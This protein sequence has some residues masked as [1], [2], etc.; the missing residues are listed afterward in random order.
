MSGSARTVRSFC[1]ISSPSLYADLGGRESI[2]PISKLLQLHMSKPTRPK[3]ST[4]SNSIAEDLSSPNSRP[5]ESSSPRE[6][7]PVPSSLAL[8]C[9][10]VN[11][12]IT[13]RKP[14]K[15]S[16]FWVCSGRCDERRQKRNGVANRRLLHRDAHHPHFDR[17]ERRVVS[18][19]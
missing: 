15:K 13:T 12:M 17:V 2:P 19:V 8:T 14:A 18:R 16:V 7:I 1:P 3:Q 10:R 9:P 5:R 4:S 6:L 11:G